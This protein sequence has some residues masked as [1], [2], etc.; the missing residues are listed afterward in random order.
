MHDPCDLH[1]PDRV[2]VVGGWLGNAWNPKAK[3]WT[4]LTTVYETRN[5]FMPSQHW[6]AL[7]RPTK[8]GVCEDVVYDDAI[9]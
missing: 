4:V 6:W 8:F 1:G 3:V 9:E 5:G 2:A 7:R